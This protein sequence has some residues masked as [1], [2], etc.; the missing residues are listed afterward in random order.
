MGRGYK[1]TAE[2][3]RE[4]MEMPWATKAEIA[5]AIPPS[6]TEHIAHYLAAH[7]RVEVAT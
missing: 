6:Y 4:A 1:G 7:L 5:Q 2:E 3:Y